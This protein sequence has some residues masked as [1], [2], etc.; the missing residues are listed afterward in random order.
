MPQPYLCPVCRENRTHFQLIYKLGQ[1]VRKDPDSGAIVF[2]D[3][4]WRAILRG[5]QLDVDVTCLVCD[6]TGHE[7]RFIEMARRDARAAHRP[8]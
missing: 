5:Q 1:E 6:Y 8:R 2:A 7:S 3:E 4:E